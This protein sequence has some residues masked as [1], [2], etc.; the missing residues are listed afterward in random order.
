MD[1]QGNC[2]VHLPEPL[3]KMIPRILAEMG[4]RKVTKATPK[5]LNKAFVFDTSWMISRVQIRNVLTGPVY[6]ERRG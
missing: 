6:E 1:K 4:I 5:F 3:K 2:E